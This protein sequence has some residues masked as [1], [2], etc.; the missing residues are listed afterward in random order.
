MLPRFMMPRELDDLK[1]HAA[2]LVNEL[3][4]DVHGR[5]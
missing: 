3:E 2:L 1:Q 5:P 4:G